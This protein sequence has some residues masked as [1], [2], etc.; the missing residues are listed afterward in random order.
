MLLILVAVKSLPCLRSHDLMVFVF[1]CRIL[2]PFILKTKSKQFVNEYVLG[3]FQLLID[4]CDTKQ[5]QTITA[6]GQYVLGC[7]KSNS[8]QFS[9]SFAWRRM[10]FVTGCSC[11]EALEN[12]HRLGL[13]RTEYSGR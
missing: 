3:L 7:L 10:D 11:S 9:I 6:G 13:Y 2:I 4:L 12:L 1:Q 8:F 5:R